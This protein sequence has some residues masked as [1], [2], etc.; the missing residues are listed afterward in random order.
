LEQPSITLQGSEVIIT[1][2][3][4]GRS[5]DRL[6]TMTLLQILG[7]NL[8]TAEIDIPVIQLEPTAS[9]LAE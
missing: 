7:R 9:N 1:P 8:Q 4:S 6:M 5:V 3:K 2:G